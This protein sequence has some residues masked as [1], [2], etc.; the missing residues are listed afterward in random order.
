MNIL[1]RK[2]VFLHHFDFS[3]T[4]IFCKMLFFF[5]KFH[6]QPDSKNVLS[7]KQLIWFRF[8]F[9]SLS[10]TQW[11][12]HRLVRIFYWI[13]WKRSSFQFHFVPITNGYPVRIIFEMC[14]NVEMRYESVGRVDELHASSSV[15]FNQPFSFHFIVCKILFQSRDN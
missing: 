9:F 7:L 3:G 14:H 6:L 8:S 15:A 5:S 11:L 4:A 1:S 13:P 12:R 10:K 2:I